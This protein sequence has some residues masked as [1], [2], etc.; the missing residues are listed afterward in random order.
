MWQFYL[1]L[2]PSVTF[3]I[4]QCR[5]ITAWGPAGGASLT[6]AA[7]GC[8]G[9]W[10]GAASSRDDG[11]VWW[12]WW[13]WWYWMVAVDGDIV[14]RSWTCHHVPGPLRYWPYAGRHHWVDILQWQWPIN[15]DGTHTV[16]LGDQCYGAYGSGKV[17]TGDGAGGTNAC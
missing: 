4:W 1:R 12:Y 2:R 10:D 6:G 9:C 11:T 5:P 15:E 17:G 3:Y 8:G 14:I 13:Y 16:I 7:A